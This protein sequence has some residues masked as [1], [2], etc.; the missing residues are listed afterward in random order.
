MGIGALLTGAGKAENFFRCAYVLSVPPR[1]PVTV[2]T[3]TY[4]PRRLHSS[5]N[6][7]SLLGLL[8]KYLSMYVCT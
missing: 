7:E 3:R 5:C 8:H 1:E 6:P 2:Y 4:S